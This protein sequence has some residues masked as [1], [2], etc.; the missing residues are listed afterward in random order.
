MVNLHHFYVLSSCLLGACLGSFAT[1]IIYRVPRGISIVMPR[2]FC[3]SCTT[4]LSAFENIPIISWLLLR[5]RCSTCR[6]FIGV[7]PIIIEAVFA[8]CLAALY[9]RFGFSVTLVERFTFVFLLICLAYIDLD[10]FTLP[11]RLIIALA[12][13]G[14]L[15]IVIYSFFPDTYSPSDRQPGFLALMVFGRGEF[16]VIDRLLGAAMSASLLA[17]INIAATF[18]LRNRRRL[19][20]EQWAMGWGDP[21]LVFSIGLFLGLEKMILVIFLASAL[22]AIVGIASRFFSSPRF[23]D[24]DIAE[25]AV[26]YGPFLA[27][28]AIYVHLW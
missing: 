17:I 10:T 3:E 26:P 15:S 9:L 19:S 22:G 16:S 13:V 21:L 20:K 2:S 7:R 24:D 12:V 27:L 28:A 5:G 4:K 23:I 11:L 6:A 18:W 1:A 14:I 25:G 8:I